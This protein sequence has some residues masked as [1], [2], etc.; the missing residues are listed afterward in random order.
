MP[1]P[2]PMPKKILELRGS[3]RAKKLDHEPP[4]DPRRPEMPAWIEKDRLAAEAWSRLT[5]QLGIMGLLSRTDAMAV[6][7]Y[8]KVWANWR[9]A[10]DFIFE[11]GTVYPIKDKSGNVRHVST[12]PQTR[13]AR[14]LAGMLTQL[15]D[16]FGL[17]PAARARVRS[18][19]AANI[20][21]DVGK[22]RFF[23]AG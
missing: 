15:E 8:A 20:H 3:W 17:S 16:R 11:K 22:S 10:E 1:G 19:G 12:W 21:D 9:R 6:E 5:E 4:C 14:N 2:Q 23:N 7:R 18:V 13:E